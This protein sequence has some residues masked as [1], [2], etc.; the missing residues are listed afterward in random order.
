MLTPTNI[1]DTLIKEF[2]KLEGFDEWF[3]SIDPEV[4]VEFYQNLV[5]IMEAAVQYNK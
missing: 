1:V 3:G 5:D 2:S 4:L